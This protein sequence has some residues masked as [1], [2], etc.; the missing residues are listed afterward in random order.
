VTDLPV[1]ATDLVVLGV[2]LLS[3]V[4][5]LARGFV[6]EVLGIA[7]WVGAAI[8]ALKLFPYV[9]PIARKHIPYQLA[10]DVLAGAGVF[11]IVLVTLSLISNAIA[12]R[13][14]ESDIGALDRSLGF[15][16]GLLR[17]ALVLSLA[18]LA[19]V[20]FV[21]PKDQPAWI[22]E[23][24]SLPIIAYGAGLVASIAPSEIRQ[25]LQG[26][27]EA[28]AA[29][30][31]QLATH[32]AALESLAQAVAAPEGR[33]AMEL[34]LK[35]GGATEATAALEALRR[36][37]DDAETRRAIDALKRGGGTPQAEAALESLRSS[38]LAPQ[39]RRSLEALLRGD[40]SP[41]TRAALD[42]LQKDGLKESGYKDG[43]RKQMDQLFRTQEN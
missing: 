22:V 8:A 37:G 39:A 7:G 3:G 15:V 40:D 4:L 6:K 28:G 27:A 11:L 34:L 10:A 43:Q 23:A 42:A 30:Q 32:G 16:F 18:Y 1:N 26:A 29:A 36:G 12:R 33:K 20:Q 14:R 9:Q 13:V 5:A 24:R 35:A 21:S 25:G 2:L 41:E 31:A 38:G 19:L 17:G